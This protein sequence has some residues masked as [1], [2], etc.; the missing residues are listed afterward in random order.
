[1]S[2]AKSR[3]MH[4]SVHSSGFV[5][6]LLGVLLREAEQSLRLSQSLYVLA[7]VHILLFL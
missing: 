1:M 6:R 4:S 3:Q 5:S 7:S 2:I